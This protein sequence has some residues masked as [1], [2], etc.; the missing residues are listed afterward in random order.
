MK[1]EPSEAPRRH[2]SCDSI[3][4]QQFDSGKHSLTGSEAFSCEVDNLIDFTQIPQLPPSS[5]NLL[6]GLDPLEQ[7]L[8]YPINSVGGGIPTSHD[9]LF[10]ETI[11]P[12]GT[13]GMRGFSPPAIY[14]AMK[15][16]PRQSLTESGSIIRPRPHCSHDSTSAPASRPGTPKPQSYPISPSGSVQSLPQYPVSSSN[17]LSYF[18]SDSSTSI[19]LEDTLFTENFLSFSVNLNQ[20]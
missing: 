12:I 17:E 14:T 4:P 8:K 5:D 13:S 15:T 6:A 11:S 20:S 2:N 1:P 18:A 10:S 16:S 3:V 19:D 9:S 7:P